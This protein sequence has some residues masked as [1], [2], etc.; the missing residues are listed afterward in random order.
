[1][2]HEGSSN[3]IPDITNPS[4]HVRIQRGGLGIV[5][6]LR[7][8]ALSIFVSGAVAVLAISI[9]A[10]EGTTTVKTV[11]VERPVMVEVQREVTVEV[12]RVVEV[13]VTVEVLKE[14]MVPV[15]KVVTVEVFVEKIVEVE[16]KVPAEVVKEIEVE[17]PVTVIVEKPVTVVVDRR[18]M[19]E[20]EAV[21]TTAPKPEPNCGS[22]SFRRTHR[23]EWHNDRGRE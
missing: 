13:P 5:R 10:C 21:A 14:V 17:V 8:V 16:K 7:I 1:M 4:T 11:V 9:A 20:R 2:S 18:I 3:R 12:E 15:E 6:A 22:D 19:V 23:Q